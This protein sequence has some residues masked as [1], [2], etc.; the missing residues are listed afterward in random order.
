MNDGKHSC[1]NT[2]Y[3]VLHVRGGPQVDTSIALTREMWQIAFLEYGL[4][5]YTRE[6]T[7][8]LAPPQYLSQY[9]LLDI[10]HTSNEAVHFLIRQKKRSE[11]ASK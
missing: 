5:R 9:E 11:G 8:L 4:P 3:V 10:H 2:K 7:Y 6:A 1:L